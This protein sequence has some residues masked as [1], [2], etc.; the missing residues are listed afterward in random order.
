MLSVFR[1][2]GA[3]T[4]LA[5]LP[6]A[7]QT[8]AIK[9]EHYTLANGLSVYLVQDHSAAV[10]SVD[11]WYTTG[12][13]NEQSHRTGFAHLFEHM[14]FQGSA[15]VKKGEHLQLVERAGGQLNGT[16]NDDRTL[17]YETL[18]SNRLNLGLWLEADR[19]RSLAVTDSNFENQR[20]AV[21]E[22]RRMRVDN[23]PYAGAF[24]EG[25]ALLFD[26][27]T[28]FPYSHS[29]IGS[30]ADLD[31]A[32]TA[33]VQDFFHTYYA[34]NNATLTVVGDINPVATKR[35]I[36]QYF[37]GIPRAAD[38]PPV[39]CQATYSPGAITRSWDDAHATLPAVLV[40][41]RIPPHSDPDSRALDLLS[42]IL[43]GGESSRLNHAL[44]RDAKTAL[45]AFAGANSRRG[46][47]F[48]FAAAIAN[49][50]ASPDT[51]AAQLAAQVALLSAVSDTE[52]TKARNEY[53][54]RT[55]FGQQ[56]A[57]SVAEAIQHYA[58]FHDKVDEINTD[59][60]AYLAVTPADL[61]R[62]AQKY[63]VPANSFTLKVLPKAAGAQ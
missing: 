55:V 31:A 45:Q 56:T 8:P 60:S 59:L 42:T 46:P 36:E 21:K 29:T 38:P 30:M 17:Y 13:R 58:H 53:R 23:Q 1:A 24:T 25:L 18:P 16:T 37:G 6:A 27:T 40:A 33:D 50:G 57:L 54:A 11:V 39:T 10:A 32:K 43:G 62:V 44:V 26:S 52:V 4:L 19:M 15:H 48:L 20:Q 35:M 2:T 63:L 3:L 51:L 47:G 12:S 7:A 14:M 49:Q 28:C 41:Y 9:Y 34:P 61:K 5:V 22:E